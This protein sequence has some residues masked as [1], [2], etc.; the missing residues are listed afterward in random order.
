MTV[1]RVFTVLL[2]LD[3]VQKNKAEGTCRS[4]SI[5][6]KMMFMVQGWRQRD[7][8]KREWVN[9]WISSL[10][11]CGYGL[12]NIVHLY[13]RKKKG[14]RLAECFVSKWWSCLWHSDVVKKTTKKGVSEFLDFSILS[15]TQGH[16]RMHNKEGKDGKRK[17]T[18]WNLVELF[19]H[20][21]L[22]EIDLLK[23]ELFM[24]A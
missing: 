3:T 2:K 17:Q 13:R 5:Q 1:V 16:I 22:K 6:V 8:A 12:E 20:C 10:D 11:C 19:W 23:M 14:C 9:S 18:I 24:V 15:A 21:L 4:P 7:I